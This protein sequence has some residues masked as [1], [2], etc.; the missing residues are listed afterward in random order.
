MLVTDTPRSWE[1]SGLGRN[2]APPGQY[3]YLSAGPPA[4]PQAQELNRGSAS[5]PW[6]SRFRGARQNLDGGLVASRELPPALPAAAPVMLASQ[7]AAVLRTDADSG[8]IALGASARSQPAKG[9]T[10]GQGLQGTGR[11]PALYTGGQRPDNEGSCL[12]PLGDQPNRRGEQGPRSA[13]GRP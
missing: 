4:R 3:S 7:D 5:W 10:F 1:V 12:Q 11:G 13:R 2:S 9:I 8:P 6:R